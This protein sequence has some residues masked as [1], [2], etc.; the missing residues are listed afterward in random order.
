MRFL[1]DECAGPRLA[2]WLR[3]QDHV[4]FSVFDE[5][6]VNKIQVV[7]RVLTDYTDRLTGNFVVVTEKRIRFAH[8]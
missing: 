5:R 7:K 4:V 6:A 8:K 3:L 2:H 1:V